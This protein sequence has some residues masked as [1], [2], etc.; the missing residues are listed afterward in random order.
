MGYAQI[1][2]RGEGIHLRQF[3]RSFIIDDGKNRIVYV[4]ADAAMMGLAVRRD[5]SITNDIKIC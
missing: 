4:T 3:A 1:S 5:V 2:Q